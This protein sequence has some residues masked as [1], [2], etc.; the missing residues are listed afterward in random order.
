MSL[1]QLEEGVGEMRGELDQ[2]EEQLGKERKNSAT[3]GDMLESTRQETLLRAKDNSELKGQVMCL[4][5]KL[6]ELQDK[7]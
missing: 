1:L 5:G 6:I 7:L 4:Q 3:L 2:L